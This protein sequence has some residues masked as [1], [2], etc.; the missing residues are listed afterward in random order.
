MELSPKLDY[1]DLTAITDD[2]Y[3]EAVTELTASYGWRLFESNMNE[4]AKQIDHLQDVRGTDDLNYRQGQ[5]SV[6]ALVLNT[7]MLAEFDDQEQEYTK[8]AGGL[9]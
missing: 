1:L 8:A 9:H 3:R 4:M 6:I 5:L 2:E 7:R